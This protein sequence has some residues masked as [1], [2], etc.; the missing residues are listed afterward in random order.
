MSLFNILNRWVPTASDRKG[1]AK[2]RPSINNKSSA[3]NELVGK[4]DQFVHPKHVARPVE[5]FAREVPVSLAINKF[6]A[7]HNPLMKARWSSKYG[8]AT[9]HRDAVQGRGRFDA[10]KGRRR[11]WRLPA[12]YRHKPVVY[13]WGV[14]DEDSTQAETNYNYIDLDPP[15]A[16]KEQTL[17]E[18]F[19]AGVRSTSATAAKWA[20][21]AADKMINKINP[22]GRARLGLALAGLMAPPTGKRKSAGDDEVARINEAGGA[23][24]SAAAPPRVRAPTPTMDK[25]LDQPRFRLKILLAAMFEAAFK[26]KSRKQASDPRQWTRRNALA[27]HQAVFAAGRGNEYAHDSNN[28]SEVA[29][30]IIPVLQQLK[31]QEVPQHATMSGLLKMLGLM[32]FVTVKPGKGKDAESMCRASIKELKHHM[33]K[34][35]APDLDAEVYRDFASWMEETTEM[36][37]RW[38]HEMT[39]ENSGGSDYN[40]AGQWAYRLA[41]HLQNESKDDCLLLL[42]AFDERWGDDDQYIQMSTILQRLV[43]DAMQG[44]GPSSR[45]PRDGSRRRGGDERR[46]A[47]RL[48]LIA[49]CFATKQLG[50]AEA[51]E[52]SGLQS[53]LQSYARSI[54]SQVWQKADRNQAKEKQR[55]EAVL[56]DMIAL[57]NRP[58]ADRERERQRRPR[59]KAWP[60]DVPT[61]A[62]A[63][64]VALMQD[65]ATR[66][67]ARNTVR[68]GDMSKEIVRTIYDS[69]R[70][71]IIDARGK[72]PSSKKRRAIYEKFHSLKHDIADGMS[73]LYLAKLLADS[74]PDEL[75]LN[76]GQTKSALWAK[77]SSFIFGPGA[78]H[79]DVDVTIKDAILLNVVVM[80]NV[81]LQ[82]PQVPM[83]DQQGLANMELMDNIAP[84]LPKNDSNLRVL[85]MISFNVNGIRSPDKQTLL[86]DSVM[87]ATGGEGAAIVCLQETLVPDD[88]AGMSSSTAWTRS[89]YEF[90]SA[91]DGGQ[92]GLGILYDTTKLKLIQD[93]KYKD[94][95]EGK[96]QAQFLLASFRLIEAPSKIVVAGSIYY[97]PSNVAQPDADHSLHQALEV[98]KNKLYSGE[99]VA[100]FIGGD[101]NFSLSPEK[102]RE[103][104]ATVAGLERDEVQALGRYGDV[105]E[106]A[107]EL[108]TSD[109]LYT[110]IK[111]YKPSCQ[112]SFQWPSADGSYMR[113]SL[114]DG[115]FASSSVCHSE[116]DVCAVQL[117][118]SV[119]CHMGLLAHAIFNIKD[120]DKVNEMEEDGSAPRVTQHATIPRA[121]WQR[122]LNSTVGMADGYQWLSTAQKTKALGELFKTQIDRINIA[123]IG[124]DATAVDID[125]AVDN[126][127]AQI[128]LAFGKLIDQQVPSHNNR[129]SEKTKISNKKKRVKA[130]APFS[131]DFV[132]GL[133]AAVKSKQKELSRFR[134]KNKMKL[135]SSTREGDELRQ[136][137][138]KMCE[139]LS[140]TKKEFLKHSAAE[141]KRSWKEFINESSLSNAAR[142]RKFKETDNAATPFTTYRDGA[143]FPAE[144]A[145]PDTAS[146]EN[147]MRSAWVACKALRS[148]KKQ[149]M[150]CSEHG[151]FLTF[152]QDLQAAQQKGH[153]DDFEARMKLI[154]EW[155]D[156]DSDSDDD[157]EPLDLFNMAEP[158]TEIEISECARQLPLGKAAGLD[159]ISNDMLRVVFASSNKMTRTI[160][161]LFNKCIELQ[162]FPAAFKMGLM[163]PIPKKGGVVT[164]EDH[165]PITL[166]SCLGKLFEQVLSMRAW[167]THGALDADA[168]DVLLCS[169]QAGFRRGGTGALQQAAMVPLLA[170]MSAMKGSRLYCVN[171]DVMKAFDTIPH[172]GILEALKDQ[173]ASV[174]T[175]RMVKS[176]LAGRATTVRRPAGEEFKYTTTG[177]TARSVPAFALLSGIA[178]GGVL[179]PF[180]Y[181]MYE[182]NVLRRM[183]E[184]RPVDLCRLLPRDL[185]DLLPA[186]ARKIGMLGYADDKFIVA[187]SPKSAQEKLQLLDDVLLADNVRVHVESKTEA[188][189]VSDFDSARNGRT[190]MKSLVVKRPKPEDSDEESTTSENSVDVNPIAWVKATEYLGVSIGRCQRKMRREDLRDSGK[191]AINKLRSLYSATGTVSIMVALQVYRSVVLPTALYGMELHTVSKST[192]ASLNRVLRACV[193]PFR[194]FPFSVITFY[195]GLVRAADMLTLRRIAMISQAV[196]NEGNMLHAAMFMAAHRTA[197]LK[198]NVRVEPKGDNMSYHKLEI[199]IRGAQ[200]IE[201][202]AQEL[203]A[204]LNRL[205]ANDDDGALMATAMDE[206][207]GM[208]LNT[209]WFN[210]IAESDQLISITGEKN[211][212]ILQL[213]LALWT[214]IGARPGHTSAYRQVP[215]PEKFTTHEIIDLLLRIARAATVIETSRGRALLDEQHAQDIISQGGEIT[216]K[217]NSVP[218]ELLPIIKYSGPY[219]KYFWMMVV[220]LTPPWKKESE[221]CPV[222]KKTDSVDSL[223]HIMLE[224]E[225][226]GTDFAGATMLM[227]E[228][229]T[230]EEMLNKK[231]TFKEHRCMLLSNVITHD[232][233]IE[234]EKWNFDNKTIKD[235]DAVEAVG[236]FAKRAY[237]KRAK[238]IVS[239]G[240]QKVPVDDESD[241]DLASLQVHADDLAT[242][243]IDCAGDDFGI[244]ERELGEQTPDEAESLSQL[245]LSD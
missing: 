203:A 213:F 202:A 70:L 66:R 111:F 4:S 121:L 107:H 52:A 79:A 147:W 135:E 190:K 29:S 189:A 134:A 43:Y 60:H 6:A 177:T 64:A 175:V 148:K 53:L 184:K 146:A 144:F 179:S 109:Y 57:L 45:P 87:N 8:S 93:H 210:N 48:A 84:K 145:T 207:D 129:P 75:Q 76:A 143:L 95:G 55:Y 103:M 128:R 183:R 62:I 174:S 188:I 35:R 68:G 206:T 228:E 2:V 187:H 90:I 37:T 161:K 234:P 167:A 240:K 78:Q 136:H 44:G 211:C 59:V 165:R 32:Y 65:A 56:K 141:R 168:K 140:V 132:R 208:F 3:G 117:D 218:S 216:R 124:N 16:E 83:L 50:S 224:C 220:G 197:K 191:R 42:F 153:E 233:F 178:Q 17:S 239:K 201:C 82:M 241:D 217:F 235:L 214:T 244:D 77:L 242:A 1:K 54:V 139:E 89:G 122:L 49:L 115:V 237:M 108:S 10:S 67:G 173:G 222:C 114:L 112:Y 164:V 38:A 106:T 47:R 113:R 20:V 180:F 11:G 163:V 152:Y 149:S 31:N 193:T 194:S 91:P 74:K 51:Q 97:P 104:P 186:A 23:S 205:A 227:N 138:I 41:L 116:D 24:G 40:Q 181:N 80:T 154:D 185:S 33:N 101:F 130:G 18:L 212:Y 166:L 123:E 133:A 243:M 195:T 192:W 160:V 238:H 94:E 58:L 236:Q 204:L 169:E 155:I 25:K 88:F 92:R 19:A 200:P 21:T 15:R 199:D 126:I 7:P 229:I 105:L 12:P 209:A 157:A 196:R 69:V 162:H 127:T 61:I 137:E 39:S 159:A 96:T 13:D 26:F 118:A 73:V 131:S 71:D 110:D 230:V 102:A 30:R 219:S 182:N 150:P 9:P 120:E 36:L 99:D 27:S 232:I 14:S 119:T 221:P 226:V 28:A 5:A 63:H 176:M 98:F 81:H 198:I 245:Y 231:M 100:V 125:Q 22:G 34:A 46:I 85:N 225:A 171:V 86:F 170:T 158:L 72:E 156:A 215:Q 151:P 172:V 223:K 142:L